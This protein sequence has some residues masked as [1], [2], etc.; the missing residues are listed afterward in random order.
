MIQRWDS[1]SGDP[2][3]LESDLD[4][5]GARIP[6]TVFPTSSEYFKL[7]TFLNEPQVP[8]SSWAVCEEMEVGNEVAGPERPTEQRGDTT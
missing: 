8:V 5:T 7:S 6:R 4:D 3:A 1:A 2:S